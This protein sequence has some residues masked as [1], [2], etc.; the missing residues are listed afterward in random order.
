M[1]D[2]PGIIIEYPDGKTPKGWLVHP[3]TAD[4]GHK[5]NLLL[6]SPRQNPETIRLPLP[7]KG[8]FRLHIGLGATGRGNLGMTT[9]VRLRLASD[10][11]FSNVSGQGFS[12]YW[13]LEEL[14][15]KDAQIDNDVL[16]ITA[17]PS[18]GTTFAWL[19]LE[20]LPESARMTKPLPGGRLAITN[21]GYD[22]HTTLEH[23]EEQFM[24]FAGRPGTDIL[25]CVAQGNR[26]QSSL[27]K[28]GEMLQPLKSDEYCGRQLD[29]DITNALVKLRADHPAILTELADFAHSIGLGFHLSFRT[30]ACNG[31]YCGGYGS[32]QILLDHPEYSSQRRDG[33]P[34]ARWSFAV[35]EV[36]RHV[37]ALYLEQFRLC[38][39]ADGLNLI[40]IRSM[41]LM[42]FEPAFVQPFMEKYG[43]DPHTL[44]ENDE[45]ILA[46]RSDL[47]TDFIQELRKGMDQEDAR[48]GKHSKLSMIVPATPERCRF[49]GIDLQRWAKAGLIDIVYASN[50]MQT[51]FHSERFEDIDIEAFAKTL[52]GTSCKLQIQLTTPDNAPDDEA[53]LAVARRAINAGADGFYMWDGHAT[54][55]RNIVYGRLTANPDLKAAQAMLEGNPRHSRF[56]G[57]NTLG[58]VD[59]S[60]FP[61]HLAF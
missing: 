44:E 9:G 2:L 61:V 24:P 36:R 53:T 25:Y 18:N 45:R 40:F 47:M 42:G 23:L 31:L 15:W 3:Y 27:T 49:F 22:I 4:N 19:R 59:Y 8:F 33:V 35:P 20:E 34:Y 39:K 55:Q 14:P 1:K 51:R 17:L 16:E 26:P 13:E 29:D 21:D 56:I 10:P 30:G 5:G 48:T 32:D 57:F 7:V 28:V 54:L 12:W 58:G 46:L 43:V 52:A 6:T 41:P 50:S 38:G 11:R 60:E 37:A